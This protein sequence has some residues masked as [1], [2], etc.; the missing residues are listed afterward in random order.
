M[1]GPEV[2]TKQ[3]DRYFYLI[4]FL[5]ILS[6]VRSVSLI[7]RLQKNNYSFKNDREKIKC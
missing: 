1:S 7:K 4:L 6:S 2:T 5:Q 3:T